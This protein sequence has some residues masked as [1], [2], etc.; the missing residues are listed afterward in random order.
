MN[1][2]ENELLCACLAPEVYKKLNLVNRLY[3]EFFYKEMM[4]LLN[5]QGMKRWPTTE[6]GETNHSQ[7]LFS[8][9]IFSPLKEVPEQIPSRSKI[10][11]A[12]NLAR[13]MF[14]TSFQEKEDHDSID[15]AVDSLP[16][17]G[18]YMCVIADKKKQGKKK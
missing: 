17:V 9:V 14:H 2:Q 4:D 12:H 5:L 3:S 1:S 18:I 6:A 8:M 10:T 13:E 15:A 16:T 11:R 7:L